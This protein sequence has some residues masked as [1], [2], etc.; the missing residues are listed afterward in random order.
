M[1]MA[2]CR[3][4][5]T[6]LKRRPS[7]PLFQYKALFSLSVYRS[8]SVDT[9][10]EPFNNHR[11]T[12]IYKVK[13][14]E[15]LR[16]KKSNGDATALLEKWT[17]GGRNVSSSQLRS[18][19]RRLVEARRYDQAL[20][21]MNWIETEGSSFRMSA[22]DY[23]LR[24][25]VIIEVHG[26][27]VA[28]EYFKQL[29]SFVAQKAACLPLLNGFVK[30]RNIDKAEA[31]MREMNDLA[32]L[33]TPHPFNEMMK[34]YIATSQYEKVH[35]VILEMKRNQI[36]RNVLSYNLWMSACGGANQLSKAEMVF[37]EMMSDE[38]VKVGWSSLASL[39]DV[40]IR[41]GLVAKALM[42]LNDAE[43]K[44]SVGGR[45]GYFF[46]ITLYGKLKNKGGVLR[47]WDGSKRVGGRITC[48][49]YMC[50]LSCLVR[51]DAL[52]EAEEVFKEWESSSGYYDIRVS[53][54]LLGAY[55]R[56][57]LI[58]KAESL[59]LHT[60]ERGGCPNYKT[61]EILMEGWV[62]CRKMV[63]AIDAMKNGFS[64]LSQCKWR[65]SHDILMHIAE[66]FEKNGSLENASEYIKIV[67]EFGLASLPLYRLLLRMHLCAG[68]PPFD[69]IKMM[70]KDEIEM[71]DE[72]SA[73]IQAFTS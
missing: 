56:C 36:P 55:V 14:S 23:A 47:V 37:K 24:M 64:M 19:C 2:I 73:L 10:N 71:D 53:N 20:Q 8:F 6:N 21:I 70:K 25:R 15:L 50:V 38:N 35:L 22:A 46:I 72:T 62:K 40:Y 3:L 33:V 27:V 44:L 28:E 57:G 29:P 52:M 12:G 30:Q 34:L 65:P 42:V 45:L 17:R 32:L 54:V 67:H 9:I 68:R 5:V 13:K 11:D 59:H 69:I 31:F 51:M 26:L 49:N 61:W 60:L 7:N 1:I 39:A 58:E 48:A 63:K 41:S 4:V 16:L 18:V 66:H 43:K